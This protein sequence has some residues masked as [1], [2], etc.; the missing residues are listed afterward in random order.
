MGSTYIVPSVRLPTVRLRYVLGVCVA[1]LLSSLPGVSRASN[2]K[3]EVVLEMQRIE[4]KI[5]TTRWHL[6]NLDE[7][8][9]LQQELK[10][11]E[12]LYDRIIAHEGEIMAFPCAGADIDPNGGPPRSTEASDTFGAL[13]TRARPGTAVPARGIGDG[14]GFVRRITDVEVRLLATIVYIEHKLATTRWN[15]NTLGDKKKMKAQLEAAK[16]GLRRV[17]NSRC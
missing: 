10:L 6:N 11:L 8:K 5:E 12:R 1:L 4:N 16:A 7:K 2:A 15:Y 9:R 17:R 14:F 3:A 13:A